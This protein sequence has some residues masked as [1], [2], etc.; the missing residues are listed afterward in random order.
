MNRF[1]NLLFAL[2][3]ATAAISTQ[4]AFADDQKILRVAPNAD[5]S[6]LDPHT[7]SATTTR[8]HGLMVYDMLYSMD[9]NMQPQ[10][11]MVGSEN[12]SED[13]LIYRLTLRDGQ[14]FHDGQPVTSNDVVPSL[15]RWMV[16]SV[17]GQ[18]LAAYT[19]D[20]VAV[21]DTTFEIKLREPFPFVREALADLGSGMAVIMRAQDANTDPFTNIT[22]A[23]GSGPFRFMQDEWMPGVKVVYEKNPDYVS[24]SEPSS[25]MAGAKV[26]KVDKV[27]FVVLPDSTTKSTALQAGEIDFIDQLPFTQA[28]VL[29]TNQ[30]IIVKTLSPIG[31]YGFIRPNSLHAPFDKVEARQALALIVDQKEYL[32]ASFGDDSIYTVCHS[33]FICGSPNGTET[34]SEPFKEQNFEKAKELLKKSGYAGEPIYVLSSHDLDYI[35]AYGDVTI[36]N[37]QKIG[38]NV[39]IIESDWGGLVARRAQKKAPAE[40]GWHIFHT[41]LDGAV[42][43]N[44]LTNPV[45]DQNCN[46]NNYFGWPCDEPYQ[47][48]VVD[49]INEP[50]QKKRSDLVEKMSR[51]LWETVPVI[52]VGQYYQL[53]AWRKNITGM[54]EGPSLPVFW[55]I[56]KIQE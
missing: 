22:T 37:L 48:M 29:R 34:G 14:K 18:K 9:A 17:I 11:G 3:T 46:G 30:D 44:P 45:T 13:G 16:R 52:P 24:R 39:Q 19:D 25:G 42:L 47:E 33:F 50:D 31:N 54:P 7:N 49:Y 1:R 56:D 53:Y 32:Q 27:E 12:V 4:V 10:P 28:P 36:S 2:A 40:G 38:V 43:Y 51:R 41:S 21:D 26:V 35:G 8:L 6:T 23:V 55:N 15:K 20:V 5:L